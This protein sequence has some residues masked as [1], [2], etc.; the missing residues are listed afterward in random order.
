LDHRPFL[1]ALTA[2][3]AWASTMPATAAITELSIRETKPYGTFAAGKFVRIEGEARGSLAPTE[4]IADIEKAA[5]DSKG[6]V[7]YRTQF[8]M[9][10]PEAPTPG[11]GALLVDVVNRGRAVTHMFYNSPRER[12]LPPGNLDPGTGFL[13]NRGFSLVAIQWE[14]AEG[15]EP[16]TFLDDKGEKRFAEGVAFAA[17][18]DIAL[19]LRHDRSKANPLAGRVDRVHAIGYSQTARLLKTF[20]ALGFNE[21]DGRHAFD[22]LHVVAGTAGVIPLN[23]S[24]KGPGSVAAATPGPA[25]AE[26]RGVHEEPF[27]Y[28]AVMQRLLAKNKFAP[29]VMVANMNTDYLSTRT[30]LIR[31]GARGTT[32][33]PLPANVRMYDIA[34]AAHMNERRPNKACE[35]ELGQLDWS[36]AMRAQL[37]ALDDWAR[38]RAEP[39]ASRLMPL[40]PQRGDPRVLDAPK[41]L[42]DA[43]VLVPQVDQDGNSLGGVRLPDLEAPLGQ[44]GDLNSP[45]SNGT[46]RLAGSYRSFAKT[47]A[48]RQSR[49]D[50]RLS[51]EERYPGG[52]NEYTSRIRAAARALVADRLLL[53]EDAAVI[54]NAAADNVAFA[55]TPPRARGALTGGQR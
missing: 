5:R 54:E 6:R 34:G 50:P 37:V 46:C 33:A 3:A 4:P 24:G 26:L 15:I 48:E 36:P 47:A 2:L 12:P 10:I 38:G 9:I 53:P 20:L 41:F 30:S 55:L 45:M 32:E 8:T 28:E 43:V 11:N 16:P 39:P 44:H 27:T 42:P 13:Q 7:P 35:Y 18:R 40:G 51:V 52:V 23:A 1:I 29:R 49:N 25:N 17:V 21:Q 31:T 19:F 22:G 14:M